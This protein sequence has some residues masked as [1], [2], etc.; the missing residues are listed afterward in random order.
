MS[1]SNPYESVRYVKIKHPKWTKNA[2]IYQINTRQ[3]TE[4]GTLSAAEAH[5]PRLKDLG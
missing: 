4:E 1:E 5:L 2:V 3:F